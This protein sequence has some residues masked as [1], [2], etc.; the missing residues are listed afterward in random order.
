MYTI[1][2]AEK[3]HLPTS[4]KETSAKYAKVHR[5]EELLFEVRA[6]KIYTKVSEWR[7]CGCSLRLV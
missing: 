4:C 7:A 3:R 5:S 6:L 2:N 1:V